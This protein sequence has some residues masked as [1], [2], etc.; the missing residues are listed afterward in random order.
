MA[1]I[2]NMFGVADHNTAGDTAPTVAYLDFINLGNSSWQGLGL[3]G[4]QSWSSALTEGTNQT[5]Y[6]E[7]NILNYSLGTDTDIPSGTA[8]GGGARLACRFNYSPAINEFG[9]CSMH[10]TDTT[11]RPRGGLQWEGYYNF[12]T[13]SYP[14]DSIAGNPNSAQGCGSAWPARSGTGISFGNNFA[15]G[16]AQG[17]RFYGLTSADPERRWR[18]DTYGACDGGPSPSGTGTSFDTV[19]GPS[20]VATVYYSGTIGSVATISNGYVITDSNASPGWSTNQWVS[21]GTP[22][23]VFETV[24]GGAEIQLQSG[25]TI[26]V[27]SGAPGSGF[28][29]AAGDAYQIRRAFVCIDQAAR[30]N[31]A[32]LTG[33]STAPVLNST[34]LPG[35]VT[36]VISP[37]YE[38]DDALPSNAGT[39]G[40]TTMSIILGRDFYAEATNQI[41]QTNSTTP[42]NGALVVQPLTSWTTSSNNC[43][44]NMA[45]TTGLGP[46]DGNHYV[47]VVDAAP[48]AHLN[49]GVPVTPDGF[50]VITGITATSVTV[51][52]G[53]GFG[54]GDGAGAGGSANGVPVGHGTLALRPTT[55]TTGVAYL[56]TDQ[57]TWNTVDSTREGEFFTCTATNT[58]TLT[59]VPF[60]YPH[61]LITGAP[62]VVSM[63]P[64]SENFGSSLV[65][66]STAPQTAT[67]TNATAASI[68]IS[69][70][71]TTGNSADFP[72]TANTCT[73]GFVVAANGGTCTVSTKFLPTTTGSRSATLTIA[74]S[75]GS[76]NVAL[77]GVGGSNT[78]NPPSCTPTSGVVPQTVTC[79]NP[80]TGTTIMCYASSP[81]VPATNGLGTAC[82]SGTAYTTQLAISSAETL[83]VIAGVAGQSDSS[84]SSYTYTAAA[85]NCPSP[86][87]VGQFTF[88]SEAYNDVNG[89][90][91]SVSLS[92]YAGNGVELFVSFCGPAC[93]AAPPA[94]TLTI[95]DNI[96]N[97]ETC[98]VKSPHSPF[99]LANTSVPDYET[100]YA[101][102]CPSIPSG[103]TSLT[104]TA[105]TTLGALQLDAIEWKVGAIASSNYFENV[106]AFTG[107]GATTG[108]TATVVTSGPT[109]SPNDLVT[110]MIANCGLVSA[111]VG[112]GYTG[113]IVNPSSTP[114]HIVEA[115][116][117]TSIQS[118][119]AV[120]TMSWSSGTPLGNCG[121]GQPAPND[122]W[123]GIIVP[124]VG[125]TVTITPAAL[126]FGSQ[127]IGVTSPGK[128]TT[129]VNN[130][131]SAVSV[132]TINYTG[133]NNLD[134]ST[135]ATTCG[136]V[137]AN[138][139]SCT[140]TTKFTPG[141]VGS[142]SATLNFAFTGASGS[143][144]TVA[145]SGTGGSPQVASC[146]ETQTTTPNVGINIGRHVGE[147][148]NNSTNDA[149]Q[150]VKPSGICHAIP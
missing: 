22:Y 150:A 8:G 140:I 78:T 87:S 92:P 13:C 135:F 61:P 41:A 123:F 112:T 108:T 111:S 32:L 144:L 53:C 142:R 106:D 132:S 105:S 93:N 104:A 141:A 43:T 25:N 122:T 54:F 1:V 69:S 125:G 136:T 60:T 91:V 6:L 128:V 124:L 82:S 30:S 42:F 81:T 52:N 90:S 35:P 133:P 66:N 129:V 83:E 65:G 58:W 89:T 76:F 148:E 103:V 137:A 33:S 29:P 59:Y 72:N 7:N 80:N 51:G 138:G 68:T 49:G 17:A 86:T 134:F 44:L 10:G 37:I 77:S 109:V 85:P 145:L 114:G 50:W 40:S 36:Q 12:G 28:V 130:T 31:G 120:A 55:C 146:T 5:F 116:A 56:A 57:G 46:N 119:D 97:P 11:G 39:I 14:W 143:P 147:S 118:P 67:L 96:N 19:D 115:K 110:S 2:S 139:G 47:I 95:S 121:L 131:S 15:S 94:V 20:N 23:S 127:T 102:Y 64:P 63:S 24:K 38:A 99:S 27:F 88:C 126:N 107:S 18:P 34:G 71:T 79:T 74:T 101:L 21:Y 84:V 113:I 70:V 4:D 48:G 3:F 100:L 62:G 117:V 9:V 149:T 16:T 26:T 98:F 45:S 75:A 73:N